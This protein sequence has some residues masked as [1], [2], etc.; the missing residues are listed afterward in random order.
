MKNFLKKLTGIIFPNQCLACAKIIDDDGLFC[1]EDWQ[2]L[3]FITTPKCAICSQPF[4][5]DMGLEEKL[6]CPAC[7]ENRPSFDD[8]IIIFHY[9]E[10]LKK[11]IGDLKYRDNINLSK[12]FAQLLVNKLKNEAQNYD[13]I[14]AVPLHKKRLQHR[15]FNQSIL[16]AR[17]IS[18]AFKHLKFH[19]DIL[20]RTKNTKSQVSLSQ[21]DRMQNLRNIFEI[22]AKYKNEILGKKI[23]LIDDVMTTGATLDNCSQALKK[24]GAKHVTAVTIAK[25]IL[26]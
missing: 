21:K 6:I 14:I 8:S 11:A 4:A 7:L 26:S 17:F 9:N 3:K 25:N 19:P 1:N 16:L 23:L 20:L 5:F 13:L 12:K 18:K 15:K 2:K 22:N 24:A 10:P